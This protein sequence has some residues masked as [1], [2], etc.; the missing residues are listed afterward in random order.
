MGDDGWSS[1][2]KLVRRR[3][4]DNFL[5]RRTEMRERTNER[6]IDSEDVAQKAQKF[7]K[8]GERSRRVIGKR[9]HFTLESDKRNRTR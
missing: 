4:C 1:G 2:F 6:N 9:H 5:S 8:D 7:G 3:L